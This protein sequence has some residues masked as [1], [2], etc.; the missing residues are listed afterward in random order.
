MKRCV[1]TKFRI[2]EISGVDEPCQALARAA[3]FKRATPGAN[4]PK[5]PPMSDPIKKALGLADTATDAQVAAAIAKNIADAAELA[6][7]ATLSDGTR[8]H[9]ETLAKA[10]KKAADAFLDA[11]EE[12]RKKEVAKAAAGDE[13]FTSVDGQTIS[14]AAVGGAFS[15]LKAQDQRLR[16][17]DAQIKKAKEDAVNATIA[18]R[19]E[20]EFNALP[21]S[22]EERTSVL[23][24]LADAP[25]AVRTAGE[26][27][28]KAAQDAN[29]GDFKKSSHTPKDDKSGKSAESKLDAMAKKH[30]EENPGS[31]FAKSYDHVMQTPEGAALY[32]EI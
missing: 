8:A 28:F 23:K 20:T 29:A 7:K 27:I 4:T 13:T 12:D 5:E 3:I 25:E 18:K 31:T 6:K 24:Y 19:V 26:A 2:D 11:D 17:Q 22:V 15:I 1:M 32:A 10:D 16:D 9:Y 14:K 21:G 30:L